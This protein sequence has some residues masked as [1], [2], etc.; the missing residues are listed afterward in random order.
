MKYYYRQH[1]YQFR[2]SMRCSHHR[3]IFQAIYN[4]HSND[5]R[6]QHFTQILHHGRNLFSF[7]KEQERDS[8]FLSHPVKLV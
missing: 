8:S 3:G 5:C 2:N 7:R 1:S 6:R 4:Q